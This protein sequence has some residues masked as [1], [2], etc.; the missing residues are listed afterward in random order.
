MLRRHTLYAVLH[1]K[2]TQK[3][4]EELN[5]GLTILSWVQ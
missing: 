3:V 5:T 4:P 2:E 1:E